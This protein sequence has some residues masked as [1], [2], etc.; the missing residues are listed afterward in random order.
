MGTW[1]GIICG[2]VGLLVA[3]LTRGFSEGLAF[4]FGGGVVIA[5]V[6]GLAVGTPADPETEAAPKA[7]LARDRKTF[8]TVALSTGLTVGLIVGLVTWAAGGVTRGIEAGLAFAIATGLGA[9]C[10]QAA[11]GTYTVTRYW[12][13]MRRRI[14]LK[15]TAFLADAHQRRGVLRQV[16]A[17]YQFRHKELQQHLAGLSHS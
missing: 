6:G 15:L 12:L 4:G 1:L 2:L 8:Q 10:I 14:P 9:G 5:I 7:V 16:G 11:W 13:A 3:G 17:V